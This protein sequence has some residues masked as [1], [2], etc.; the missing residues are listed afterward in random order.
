MNYEVF[1]AMINYDCRSYVVL[2]ML[3]NLT[4]LVLFCLTIQ[5]STCR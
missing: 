4:L 5:F 2:A 1:L 3:S